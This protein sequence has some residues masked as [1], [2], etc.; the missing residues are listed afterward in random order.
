MVSFRSSFDVSGVRDPDELAPIPSTAGSKPRCPHPCAFGNAIELAAAIPA[1]CV[2]A[3]QARNVLWSVNAFHPLGRH[4]Y[5]ADAV[6]AILFL[7]SDRAGWIT[8]NPPGR[9]LPGRPASTYSARR[10]AAP[11]VRLQWERVARGSRPPAPALCS[12][13]GTG[14]WRP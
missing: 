14:R 2:D 12:R 7:A 1:R 9:P 5:P 13:G 3:E 11:F 10:R 6:E 4:G 8:V